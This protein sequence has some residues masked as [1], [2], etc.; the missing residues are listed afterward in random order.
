ML[1]H[2]KGYG[3]V[4]IFK[5][6]TLDGNVDYYATNDL[7]LSEF[8]QL[9]YAEFSWAI[10][11]YHRGLKHSAVVSSER[12]CVLVGRNAIVIPPMI[13]RGQVGYVGKGRLLI[14]LK[15]DLRLK[16]EQPER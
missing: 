10:E 5:L 2:L 4:K 3:M 13:A 15:K 12:R 11:G 6:V 1:L 14:G 16:N 8:E 7:N 9:Q